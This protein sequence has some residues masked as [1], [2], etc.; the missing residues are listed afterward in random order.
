MGGLEKVKTKIQSFAHTE[1]NRP[2]IISEENILNAI[3]NGEDIFKREGIS[4]KF[5]DPTNYPEPIRSLM[6]EYPQFVKNEVTV[7]NT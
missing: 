1:F 4:Y 6:L 5:V 3:N 7:H 2:D